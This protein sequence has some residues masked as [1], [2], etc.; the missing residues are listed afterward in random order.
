MADIISGG[1]RFTGDKKAPVKKVIQLNTDNKE[2]T[3]VTDEADYEEVKLRIRRHRIR[4]GVLVL[5]VVALIVG[6]VLLAMHLLDGYTYSSYSITGSLNREDTATSQYIA[7]NGGYIKYSNDGASYYTDKGKAIWNQ[8]Y[9]MQKPQVKMCEDCVAI[10]DINGN[11]VYVF[12]KTG[13]L[14]KIDTSLVISQ[15][16]VASNGAVVAVLED[17]EANYINMYS[18]EGTK[19]YSIKTTV[20]GDGYPLDVSISNDAT[21]LM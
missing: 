8:T 1:S 18:K 19:I 4:M 2:Q 9:S 10:G 11:T 13:M 7:Y 20:S 21:K 6:A 3:A 16:E 17:N 14:G 5:I 15:I 12:N